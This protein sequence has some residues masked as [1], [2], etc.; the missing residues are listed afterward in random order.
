MPAAPVGIVGNV[1]A[2]RPLLANAIIAVG[3]IALAA[4]GARQA[5]NIGLVASFA[6]AAIY[7]VALPMA[8]AALQPKRP[9]RRILFLVLIALV[10][11]ALIAVDRGV[12]STPAFIIAPASALTLAA[13]G[14]AAFLFALAPLTANVARLCVVAPVA[15]MLG[16]VGALGYFAFEPMIETGEGAAAAGVA[17]GLGVATGAGVAADFSRFFAA[18]AERRRAAAAAGHA[19]LAILAYSLLAVAALFGVQTFKTNFGA[20]EW[21]VLWAGFTATAAASTAALFAVAGA[22]SLAQIGEQ[23]AVDENRRR[24]WFASRWRPVR[25]ILPPTSAGAVSA[26]AGVFVVIAIFEA[27]F[28]AP[29]SLTVFFLLVWLA[30]AAAFVSARTSLLV[31]AI[32]AASAVLAGYA[33]AVIGIKTPDLSTRLAAL[34]LTAV[35]VGHMTVS[36]RNAGDI[37]RNARDVT[38]NALSDGLRRFLFVFGAGAASLFVSARVFAWDEG[39]DAIVYFMTTAFMSVLLAPALMTTLSAGMRRY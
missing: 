35:A 19:G 3:L 10:A 30:A 5:G 27:G 22:L 29:V 33:Y 38:E 28:S 37:W 21:R 23:A 34:A 13:A 2:N 18:G 24:Q 12:I 31:L 8:L 11:G 17:L 6:G 25:R 39:Y 32:L 9:L 7:V 14:F 15:S 1:A 36:W 4:L 26:I 16:V 20:V